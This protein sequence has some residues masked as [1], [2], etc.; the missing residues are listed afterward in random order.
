MEERTKNYEK[1][2]LR[3][4]EFYKI[5]LNF[6]SKSFHPIIIMFKRDFF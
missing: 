2:N 3:R 5:K 1:K 4:K 6:F